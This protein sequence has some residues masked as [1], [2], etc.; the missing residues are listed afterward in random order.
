MSQDFLDLPILKVI[1]RIDINLDE[2]KIENQQSLLFAEYIY[3]N[4]KKLGYLL[5]D[6]LE[7]KSFVKI[8]TTKTDIALFIGAE[9][10]YN[11]EQSL[12]HVGF[13][14]VL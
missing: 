3:R 2:S 4:S 7:A 13:N 5:N 6:V 14:S 9:H 11:I 12:E 8:L 1:E 10:A